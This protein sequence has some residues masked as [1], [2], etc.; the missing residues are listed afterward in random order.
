M[1]RR[2]LFES[3]FSETTA[4]SVPQIRDV[5]VPCNAHATIVADIVDDEDECPNDEMI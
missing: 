3:N 4:S 2:L 1:K 5:R